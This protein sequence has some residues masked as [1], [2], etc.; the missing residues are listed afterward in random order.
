[1]P[2][3]S[4][5][6][7]TIVAPE[8]TDLFDSRSAISL[9]VKWCQAMISDVTLFFFLPLSIPLTASGGQ[10]FATRF[11]RKCCACRFVLSRLVC[12]ICLASS[13]CAHLRSRPLCHHRRAINHAGARVAYHP[14][15][16]LHPAIQFDFL[17][18]HAFLHY[19][20]PFVPQ[21]TND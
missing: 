13:H 2:V 5:H 20:S 11:Q 16:A 4:G 12:L 19:P 18:D 3:A 10:C 1:M 17:A 8:R 9:K 15:S 21:H 6:V 14:V 7:P